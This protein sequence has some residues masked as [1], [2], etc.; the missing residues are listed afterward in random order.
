LRERDSF[1]I[2]AN[3]EGWQGGDPHE[4]LL[5]SAALRSGEIGGQEAI[6]RKGG[7]L[8]LLSLRVSDA[9]SICRE[10]PRG[11]K[12]KNMAIGFVRGEKGDFILNRRNLGACVK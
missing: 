10:I 4:S 2:S 6:A 3:R 8:R 7:D 12:E 5:T 9:K 1:N 11:Q